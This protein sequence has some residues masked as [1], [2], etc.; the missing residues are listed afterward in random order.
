MSERRGWGPGGP[1]EEAYGR[2]TNV[3]RFR[4][5]HSTM[6]EIV[7][8]LEE[9][10]EV[11]RTEGYGLD[12]ELEKGLVL[13]RPCVRLSPR[14]PDAAP[15][16]VAFTA[17]P[18]LHIRFGRWHTEL[19][20]VCGCDACAESTEDEIERLNSMV[21]AVTAGRFRETVQRPLIPSRGYGW[22]KA[23]FWSPVGSSS[24]GSRVDG[25]SAQR[26]SG[27]RRRLVLDWK[28]WPTGQTPG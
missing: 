9:G 8:R 23:E 21:E 6:L 13:A 20:P 7:D 11:E 24:S 15:I 19:F 1:P 4:P 18:G 26:M 17:F 25:R 10:F 28:P 5:L 3:E 16:A 14:D 27:G 22:T 2:L 12:E